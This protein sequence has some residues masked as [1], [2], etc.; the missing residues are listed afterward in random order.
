[1]MSSNIVYRSL[2]KVTICSGTQNEQGMER[3]TSKYKRFKN[4]YIYLQKLCKRNF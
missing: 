3:D 2:R 4:I 1:M